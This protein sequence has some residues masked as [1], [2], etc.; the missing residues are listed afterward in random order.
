MDLALKGENKIFLLDK[1]N[2]GLFITFEGIDG[3]GKSTQ[4]KM[5]FDYLFS[6]N[7]YNHILMTREPYRN[8]DIRKLLRSESDP[9]SQAELLA[10]LFVDDRKDH[11]NEFVLPNLKKGIH[12]I[13][14]RYSFST[15]AYQQAQG[16]PLCELLKM[17][18]GLLIPDLIFLIDVPV[19]VALDRMS[20]DGKRKIE[21]KFEK[22]S[23]FIEKLRRNYLSLASL[24]NH[25]VAVIDGTGGIEQVFERVR[26]AYESRFG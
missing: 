7:K 14:D 22:K 24:S 21:Q 6:K 19:E 16:I 12:I 10:R 1:M 9:Y 20:A 15:L 3:C 8:A 13:S 11:V 26:K 4:V 5:F 17:H 23:E 25:H 18:S 2:R